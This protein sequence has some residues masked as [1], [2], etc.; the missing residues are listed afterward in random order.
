MSR[1]RALAL[2]AVTGLVIA[3]ACKDPLGGSTGVEIVSI[4]DL[5]VPYPTVVIGDVMRDSNGVAAPVSIQGFDSEGRVITN[6]T[7]QITILDGTTTALANSI[8]IDQFGYVHGIIRDTVGARVYAGFGTLVA[9]VQRVLV[10]VAPQVATKSTA[11][12]AINFDINTPDTTALTNWASL[13][14]TLADANGT[15]AQG[16][17]IT[18]AVTR[19]PT[20]VAGNTPT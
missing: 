7:P 20:A 1:H 13:G 14:L 16:F 3:G 11:V 4:S 10:S 12:T 18:Y 8:H 17:V 15:A 19:S 2:L 5:K 6:A 9:P